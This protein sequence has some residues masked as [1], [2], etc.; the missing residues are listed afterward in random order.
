MRDVI[1]FDLDGT[2]SLTDHRIHYL[3]A[4]PKDWDSFYDEC[5]NDEPNRPVIELL[6]DLSNR[7]RPMMARRD[8]IWILTGRTSRV[9]AK[10]IEWLQRYDIPTD[11]LIMRAEGDFSPDD[12]LKRRWIEEHGLRERVKY[13]FEDRDRVVEMWRT[14]GFTC[15][16]VG[17]GSF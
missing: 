11:R 8:E 10:T 4:R 7:R 12:Q 2:L 6:Q 13:V 16:Q 9:R 17:E 3:E 1:I 5:G 14:E 15:F